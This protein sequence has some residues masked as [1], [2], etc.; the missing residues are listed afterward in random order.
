MFWNKGYDQLNDLGKECVESWKVYNPDWELRFLDSAN[1][2]TY[3]DISKWEDRKMAWCAR[4]DML[5]INLLA[6]YGG[7]WADCDVWCHRPLDEWLHDW[8]PKGFFAF[9]LPETKRSIASWFLASVKGNYLTKKYRNKVA[10]YWEDKLERP[11]GEYFWLHYLFAPMYESDKKIKEIWDACKKHSGFDCCRFR[12][13]KNLAISGKSS[14]AR[15]IP[16]SIPDEDIKNRILTR[17]DPV[18]KL[19]RKVH[20]YFKSFPKGCAYDLLKASREEYRR[21]S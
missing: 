11:E 7:V 8:G 6:D 19:N 5:R 2:E 1:V 3:F 21:K 16:N 13:N 18:Y 4:A 20:N 10:E 15:I 12:V 9:S 14:K 17:Q